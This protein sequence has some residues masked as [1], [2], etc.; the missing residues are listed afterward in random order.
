VWFVILLQIP[1]TPGGGILSG[2]SGPVLLIITIVLLIA[3]V[4]IGR[5]VYRDAKRQGSGY[6][7]LWGIG[8]AVLFLAGLVPGLLGLVLY[9]LLVRR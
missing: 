8:V 6:A 5:W 2:L 7:W 9:L 1:E 3:I 4:L